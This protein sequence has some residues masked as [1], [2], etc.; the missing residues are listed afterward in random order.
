MTTAG[1]GKIFASAFGLKDAEGNSFRKILFVV[2]SKQITRQAAE[3]YKKVFGPHS[4]VSA[5]LLE[6]KKYDKDIIFATVQTLSKDENL[7][8]FNK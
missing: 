6:I 7:K 4:I 3:S 5:V 8:G 1:I 2:H